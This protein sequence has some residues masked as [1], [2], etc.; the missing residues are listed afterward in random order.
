MNQDRI[1]KIELK[2][3]ILSIPDAKPRKCY[4]IEKIP[5]AQGGFGKI[6]KAY[7]IEI[8]GNESVINKNKVFVA[9]IITGSVS[10]LEIEC[11]KNFHGGETPIQISDKTICLIYN[12]REGKDLGRDSQ[13]IS[14]GDSY[15]FQEFPTIVNRMPLAIKIKVIL[16]I[17]NKIRLLH[18]QGIIHVDIK[19]SNIRVSIQDDK[20]EVHLLDYGSSK[21]LSSIENPDKLLSFDLIESTVLAPE[22][23]DHS[24]GLKSD[25]YSFAAVILSILGA[26]PLQYIGGDPSSNI[27]RGQKEN[28]AL[29]GYPVMESKIAYSLCLSGLFCNLNNSEKRS[30]KSQNLASI[31]FQFLYRMTLSEHFSPLRASYK[32]R[33]TSD[34]VCIFFTALHEYLSEKNPSR[35]DENLAKLI[36]LS[37]GAWDK[38]HKEMNWSSN[39][40]LVKKIISHSR[41]HNKFT[42]QLGI[43]LEQCIAIKKRG[44]ISLMSERKSPVLESKGDSFPKL[45]K[46]RELYE[47]NIEAYRKKSKGSAR[48][49]AI[50]TIDTFFKKLAINKETKEDKIMIGCLVY[51]A[52]QAA[53]QHSC[54]LFANG[55]SRLADILNK[56]IN[57]WFIYHHKDENWRCMPYAELQARKEALMED[58]LEFSRLPIPA[59]TR[60][61]IGN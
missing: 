43:P 2:Y 20:I 47:N 15:F 46:I 32:D 37:S 48:S 29:T 49:A 39:K 58:Y 23:A 13:L 34:Q 56:T 38:E 51:A 27:S 11:L 22:G 26:R 6:Y 31:I 19:L 9:K 50:D 14:S 12:Y 25:I 21:R 55:N 7:P 36:L 41:Q 61:Q 28:E 54:Q 17:A 35:N 40:V 57:E 24:L 59:Q 16:E 4:A 53:T 1:S 10:P 18:E 42:K 45:Q 8:N 5:F 60:H 52:K 30:L 3:T 33:P 44:L